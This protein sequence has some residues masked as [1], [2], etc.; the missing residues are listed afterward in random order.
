MNFLRVEEGYQSPEL[1]MVVIESQTVLA[2]SNL[3]SPQDGD[4]WP[5]D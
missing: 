4:E 1:E 3:E 2:Q 5:W